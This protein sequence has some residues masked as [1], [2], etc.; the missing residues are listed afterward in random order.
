MHLADHSEQCIGK[1]KKPVTAEEIC[2]DVP[3]G[4]EVDVCTV[5]KEHEQACS[6]QLGEINVTEMRIDFLTDSQKFKLPPFRV[7]PKTCKI[8]RAKI[9]KKQKVVFVG[10]SMSNWADQVLFVPEKDG[11]LRFC[12]EFSKHN[13]MKVKNTYLLI[14]MDECIDTIGEEQYYKTLDVYSG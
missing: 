7:G 4:K 11:K 12:F 10:P 14:V 3:V 6:D 2:I 5:L 9:Q 8:N 1:E 13:S